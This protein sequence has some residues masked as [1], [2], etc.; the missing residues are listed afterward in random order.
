M[1]F[2]QDKIINQSLPA[3]FV[4]IFIENVYEYTYRSNIAIFPV[5][6]VKKDDRYVMTFEYTYKSLMHDRD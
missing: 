5:F 3:G 4:F 2:L 6:N 1:S